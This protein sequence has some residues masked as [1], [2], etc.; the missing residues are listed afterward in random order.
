MEQEFINPLRE[1]FSLTWPILAFPIL[2]LIT[3]S[4]W[5]YWRQQWFKDDIKY[6]LLE[7]RIP[8]LVTKGPKG[9]EQVL[10]A[11]HSLRNAPGDLG[12]WYYWGETVRP[13]T[14]ELVSFGGEVH[15][16]IRSYWKLAGLIEAAFVSYYP[17]LEIVEVED[18]VNRLPK[19]LA[20][21]KE[22]GYDLWGSEM[23]LE[24][25]AAYPIKTFNDFE[26]MD[27]NKLVDPVA[28]F[29]EV[30]AQL[31]KGEFVG[32][33]II[34][35]PDDKGWHDRHEKTVDELRRKTSTR[36]KNTGEGQIDFST[37]TSRTPGQ[38]AVI[39]AM[40]NKLSQPAFVTY[41]RFIYLSPKALFYDSFARRGITGSFN[42]FGALDLNSFRQNYKVSTRTRIWHFPFLFPGTR[43]VIR[44]QRI[45]HDYLK[46]EVQPETFMGRVLSS[47]FFN[48]NFHSK[49]I[50]LTVEEIASLFHPPTEGVLTA[51]HM[52]RIESRKG[53]PQVGLEI[54][55]DDDQIADFT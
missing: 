7:I 49:P 50:Q 54:F 11:V 14:L 13:F 28:T 37:F 8:R 9:M 52:G 51:P 53:A 46:R 17:D 47:H 42:Q 39:E 16:Y 12:E 26:V 27:E 2:W 48:W 21:M 20:Q 29:L 32:I 5:L 1:V 23:L 44:Q 36:A 30:Y 22:M 15:F 24:K 34:M 6:K 55:G 40:E 41:L 25:S 19:D 31:K 10:R 35:Q 38:T 33:Q 18:Y 4:T 45:L 3:R 43:N